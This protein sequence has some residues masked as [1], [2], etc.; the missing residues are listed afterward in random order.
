MDEKDNDFFLQNI[1][2]KR[3][4]EFGGDEELKG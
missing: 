4:R 2:N 3:I 1:D